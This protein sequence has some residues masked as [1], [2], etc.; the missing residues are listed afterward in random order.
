MNFGARRP[1]RLFMACT[2]VTALALATVPA[3]ARTI[4]G[5]YKNN[6]LVGTKKAD[7]I[8]AMGGN[9][10]VKGRGGPDR[11]SGGGGNDRVQGDSGNDDLALNAGDD[12][13]IGGSD[14]DRI[15]GGGGNDQSHGGDGNDY[16]NLGT[17]NDRGWGDAGNDY[18]QGLTGND[19]VW[20]GDG[21]DHV[22]GADGDDVVY[23]EAGPDQLDGGSGVDYLDGG[24]GDESCPG[25]GPR[26]NCGK[27][28]APGITAD[29]GNDVIIPGAGVD[30]VFGEEGF[31]TIWLTDD[32]D[33]DRI[34][35][36]ASFNDQPGEG[37]V[38]YEGARDPD[39]EFPGAAGCDILVNQGPAPLPRMTSFAN[40]SIPSIF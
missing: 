36:G 23:G 12:I 11:L 14:N 8:N 29:E 17:E 13:G 1:V 2:A 21:S 37:V 26:V 32:N 30:R 7:K 18:V 31:D 19:K 4:N 35:C 34:Y 16:L 22:S 3:D 27:P 25:F 6:N 24:S 39:D 9:D 33:Y 20:G 10:K 38:R 40:L 28:D 5:N 15:S